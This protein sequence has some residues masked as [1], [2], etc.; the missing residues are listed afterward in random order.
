LSQTLKD[1]GHQGQVLS[2]SISVIYRKTDD[3]PGQGIFLNTRLNYLKSL[4][5]DLLTEIDELECTIVACDGH[6]LNFYLLVE[7]FRINLIKLALRRTG[8]RQGEAARLL[9]VKPTTL[10]AM[11]IRYGIEL[12]NEEIQ[13]NDEHPQSKAQ[14][15]M[16]NPELHD[17]ESRKPAAQG[18]SR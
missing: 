6:S 12:G 9:G 17:A 15:E 18:V 14:T 8:G 4:V 16:H 1:K 3:L 7:Q 5:C 13:A 11:K 2:K 10:S